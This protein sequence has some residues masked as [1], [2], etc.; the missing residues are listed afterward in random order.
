MAT[1]R[2]KNNESEARDYDSKSSSDE[3]SEKLF[4]LTDLLEYQKEANIVRKLLEPTRMHFKHLL[5]H[6]VSMSQVFA[7]CYLT[8][9]HD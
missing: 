9:W 5:G 6:S 3:E 4:S 1:T 8:E 2:G 7:D